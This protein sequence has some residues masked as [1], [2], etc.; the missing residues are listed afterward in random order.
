MTQLR[1]VVE[2]SSA[3]FDV[4]FQL[5]RLLGTEEKV[6]RDIAK[7]RILD[8][9]SFNQMDRRENMVVET[10]SNT[11]EWILEDDDTSEKQSLLDEAGA[12]YVEKLEKRHQCPIADDAKIQARERLSSW[13]SAERTSNI[14]HL[15][16]KLGSGK[17]TLM[18]F[19]AGSPRT[20]ER[21]NQWASEC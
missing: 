17:Y 3:G 15:S 4:Q 18:K 11:Y 5:K 16:G 10:Y 12:E 19:I 14:F 21:L 9:L 8:A 2:M 1:R 6:F 20:A 7:Q 13:L